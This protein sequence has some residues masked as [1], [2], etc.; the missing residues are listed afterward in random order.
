MGAKRRTG[1][2][3]NQRVLVN[4]SQG[5]RSRG[6]QIAELGNHACRI[7]KRVA[8]SSIDRN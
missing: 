6:G 2:P 7:A 1:F 4:I 8:L 3:G 5:F